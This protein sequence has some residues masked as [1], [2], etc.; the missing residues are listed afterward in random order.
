[1]Y[2]APGTFGHIFRVIIYIIP[3]VIICAMPESYFKCLM[4]AHIMNNEYIYHTWG[5]FMCIM[6]QFYGKYLGYILI[7]I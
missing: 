4:Y 5:D 2:N 6:G 7:C 3:E 1:M